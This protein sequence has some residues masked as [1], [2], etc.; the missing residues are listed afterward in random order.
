[1]FLVSFFFPFPVVFWSDH[2]TSWDS[3]ITN[4]DYFKELTVTLPDPDMLPDNDALTFWS[5]LARTKCIRLNVKS[6]RPIFVVPITDFLIR[7]LESLYILNQSLHDWVRDCTEQVTSDVPTL[8]RFLYYGFGTV[9]IRGD[10]NTITDDEI[11]DKFHRIN[12]VHTHRWI[13]RDEIHADMRACVYCGAVVQL[14]PI[15]NPSSNDQSG[16]KTTLPLV[17]EAIP[18]MNIPVGAENV[19][20]HCQDLYK[21]LPIDR[22]V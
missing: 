21:Q 17:I 6:E 14:R 7:K 9:I 2:F 1:M 8:D 18:L 4:S 11:S 13:V 22:S 16:T 12:P 20:Q 10:P 19:M 15:V 5:F 3:Y